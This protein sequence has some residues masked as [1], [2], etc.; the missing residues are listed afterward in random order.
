MT[1]IFWLIDVPEEVQAAA[2]P[3]VDKWTTL[4]PTWCHTLKIG[5]NDEHKDCSMTAEA[6]VEYR[7]ATITFNPAW[8]SARDREGDVVHELIHLQLWPMT[9]FTD[10]LIARVTNEVPWLAEFMKEQWRQRFEGV[11]EDIRLSLMGK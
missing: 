11:V 8:L 1:T 10:D 5:W 6:D 9:H 3:F 7:M 4:I 2:A